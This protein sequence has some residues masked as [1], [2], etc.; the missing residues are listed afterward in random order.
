MIGLIFAAVIGGFARDMAGDDVSFEKRGLLGRDPETAIAQTRISSSEA[1]PRKKR[2][3]R[4]RRQK[5]PPLYQ[6][7]R[8]SPWLGTQ[9]RPAR[10]IDG[11]R[12]YYGTASGSYSQ[13]V[14]VGLATTAAVPRG[15]WKYIL[16]RRSR[17]QGVPRK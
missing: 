15:K 17:V 2:K 9:A 8:V 12:V 13:H 4:K 11:Y 7:L 1:H 6:L 10:N 16:L 3:K 14:D 5:E